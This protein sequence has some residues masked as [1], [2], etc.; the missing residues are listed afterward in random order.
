VL[1][2]FPNYYC[3]GKESRVS[4]AQYLEFCK[5]IG[6]KFVV[7]RPTKDL[8]NPDKID[9]CLRASEGVCDFY[10]LKDL[11]ERH[12]QSSQNLH[13]RVGHAVRSGKINQSGTKVLEIQNKDG[14]EQSQYQLVV[15]AIYANHNSFCDWFD[16]EKRSFQFNL[17]ELD[18]VQLPRGLRLGAT[19]MDGSYPSI[20]PFGNSGFH[21]MAHVDASQLVRE[22]SFSKTPLMNRLLNIESNWEGI[23]KISEEYFPMLSEVKYIR[24]FFV[25]RVVDASRSATDARTTELVN[26]GSGCY[27]I[28]AAKVITCVSTSRKLSALIRASA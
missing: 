28:F 22:S 19:I 12:L 6:L 1:D 16:F 11:V 17:Q 18:I 13:V 26:H 20:L 14:I 24:S 9:L 2:N 8:I 7:E 3:V 4:P 15:S 23:R 10:V 21:I 25:D 5:S 27:S